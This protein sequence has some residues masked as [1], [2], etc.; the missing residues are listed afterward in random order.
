[1][2]C[3]LLH[4]AEPPEGAEQVAPQDPQLFISLCVFTQLPLQLVS[5]EGQLC[6]HV[7]EVQEATIPPDAVHT[8][9][10]FPQLLTSPCVSTQAPLQAVWDDTLHTYT[11]VP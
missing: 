2:H 1:M 4:V 7:P 11:Q 8:F 3:P 6:E 9:P 5:P 10:H